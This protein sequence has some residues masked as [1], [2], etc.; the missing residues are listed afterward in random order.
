MIPTV[1]VLDNDNDAASWGEKKV[2]VVMESQIPISNYIN[3][4]RSLIKMCI[5]L[6]VYFLNDCLLR[7]WATLLSLNLGEE[8]IHFHKISSFTADLKKNRVKMIE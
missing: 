2:S 5:H 3:M 7:T 4:W 1:S 6:S 8:D